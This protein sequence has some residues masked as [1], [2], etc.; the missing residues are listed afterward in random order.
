M[1]GILL[2]ILL[3]RLI[4]NSQ[5]VCDSFSCAH[6]ASIEGHLTCFVPWTIS[7]CI[8][9]DK[10]SSKSTFF[11]RHN[12]KTCSVQF[13]R[14]KTE[15]T[16]TSPIRGPDLAR[17][18]MKMFSSHNLRHML[19]KRVCSMFPTIGC[20]VQLLSGHLAPAA[21]QP[22]H[23]S[24]L[25]MEFIS[26][27]DPAAALS[28]PRM[29]VLFA[30]ASEVQ[31]SNTLAATEKVGGSSILH[32]LPM[33]VP[34]SL[35]DKR[36]GEA[37]TDSVAAPITK[38]ALL[39]AAGS[40]AA[41]PLLSR[42]ARRVAAAASATLAARQLVCRCRAMPYRNAWRPPSLRGAC[43]L[44]RPSCFE[45]VH[46]RW[47]PACTGLCVRGFLIPAARPRGGRAGVCMRIRV[48]S[49]GW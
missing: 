19:T 41:L 26:L 1:K 22:R 10:C 37:V 44:G 39:V 14:E 25:D 36:A 35:R 46:T 18:Q 9:F 34:E 47:C 12:A 2:T 38:R 49:G 6:R 32:I 30:K 33:V 15:N 28:E 43:F 3:E 5:A 11:G 45:R 48:G 20:C 24:S 40:V 31:H 29:A 8:A 21:I 17:W 7:S 13:F 42:A 4:F 23:S 16:T 27:R